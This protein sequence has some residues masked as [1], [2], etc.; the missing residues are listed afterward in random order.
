[1]KKKIFT[2]TILALLAIS[3]ASCQKLQARDNL[4]KGV[5]AFRAQK[6]DVAIDHFKKP[7]NWIRN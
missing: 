5:Q 4:N 7:S 3:A 6:Y 1:M 2:F